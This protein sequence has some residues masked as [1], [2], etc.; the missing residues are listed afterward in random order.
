MMGDN[1]VIIGLEEGWNNEIKAQALDRLEVRLYIQMYSFLG[2]WAILGNAGRGFESWKTILKS[3]VCEGV[4]VS[5]N[6][7]LDMSNI[8]IFSLQNM[9]QHV[10]PKVPI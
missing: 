10:H 7:S 2:L 8:V 6:S 4:H 9:L 5:L 1:Q 3:R